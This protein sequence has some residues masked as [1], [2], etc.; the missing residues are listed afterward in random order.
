MGEGGIGSSHWDHRAGV[1]WMEEGPQ[2]EGQARLWRV[3]L[4]AITGS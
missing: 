1:S 3:E 2:T 4:A